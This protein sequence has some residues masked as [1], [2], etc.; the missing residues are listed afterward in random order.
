MKLRDVIFTGYS[1]NLLKKQILSEKLLEASK[2]SRSLAQ[3]PGTASNN[4]ET[5]NIKIP[6]VT[7][8]RPDLV[9]IRGSASR[10]NQELSSATCETLFTLDDETKDGDRNEM[11]PSESQG[12]GDSQVAPADDNSLDVTHTCD[13]QSI[14]EESRKRE[15]VIMD[16]LVEI[17]WTSGSLHDEAYL[18]CSMCSYQLKLPSRKAE[19]LSHASRM[20]NAHIKKYIK[21]KKT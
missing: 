14:D 10:Q 13:S 9:K 8:V 19:G 2:T 18:N 6:D 15:G 21:I 7:P 11:I 17:Y 1:N 16:G 12:K 3:Q 4:M 5:D 20:V